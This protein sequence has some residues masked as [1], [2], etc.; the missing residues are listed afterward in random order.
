[1]ENWKLKLVFEQLRIID[2]VK[3][4]RWMEKEKAAATL[5]ALM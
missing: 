4:E 2:S 1:M 5:Y 3:L